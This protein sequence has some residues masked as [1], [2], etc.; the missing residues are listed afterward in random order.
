M[1]N[2][3]I[4]INVHQLDT[5]MDVHKY[6]TP[7]V[8]HIGVNGILEELQYNRC[9]DERPKYLIQ[10]FISSAFFIFAIL[11]PFIIT[12]YRLCEGIVPYYV[13]VCK[14]FIY[15]FQLFYSIVNVGINYSNS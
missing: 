14:L 15:L 13:G 6:A 11:I 10:T 1:Q 7:K 3:T 8:K 4:L 9:V 5:V 2:V 12:S